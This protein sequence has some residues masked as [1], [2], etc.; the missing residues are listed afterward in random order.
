[1]TNYLKTPD[2][3]IFLDG[4]IDTVLSRIES[5][6]RDMEKSVDRDYWEGLHNR[7]KNWIPKYD[8]SPVLHVN[9]DEF[10]LLENPNHLDLICDKIKEILNLE[11]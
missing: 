6:G 9:I 1:M 11:N 5:R 4:S 8:K 7:Y 2:L 3:M 10:D